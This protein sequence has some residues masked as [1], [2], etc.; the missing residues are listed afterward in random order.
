MAANALERRHVL[1]LG[2]RSAIGR[3]LI[4][5]L[6]QRGF[7]PVAVSS[8]TCDLLSQTCVEELIQSLLCHTGRWLFAVQ[9]STTYG[10]K[11]TVMARNVA[12]IVDALSIPRL[13]FVS[14]W[15]VM[16]EPSLLSTAYIRA[17][18]ECETFYRA[19]WEQQ[20]HRIRIVRPSVVIGSKAL[21]HQRLLDALTHVAAIVPD[22]LARCFVPVQQVVEAIVGLGREPADDLRTHCVLGRLCSVRSLVAGDPASRGALPALVHAACAPLRLLLGALFEMLAMICSY[23]R[24]W[25]MLSLT[26]RSEEDVLAIC[27]PF[28]VRHVQVLGRGA[29]WKYYKHSFPGAGARRA[30]GHLDRAHR[31]VRRGDAGK[32]LV[33]MGRHAGIVRLNAGSIVV[34]AGTTFTDLLQDLRRANRTLLVRTAF[35]RA[36]L[37]IPSEELTRRPGPR[38]PDPNYKF[39]TAGAAA[40]VPVHGSSLAHPLVNDCIRSLKYLSNGCAA[41]SL[42]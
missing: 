31:G 5:D 21:V 23:F 30:P 14:S 33:N 10:M 20:P 29:M 37:A 4:D 24:G 39:I 25:V 26:P 19:H 13:V 6:E 41:A 8:R 15:V 18:R 38:A 7:S 3:L 9:L 17:K 2:S 1:V 28:N 11:D 40:M 16:F 42:P 34:R 35:R 27:S 36:L 32:V 22:N 12:R